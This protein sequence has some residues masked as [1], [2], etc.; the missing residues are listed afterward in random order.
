MWRDT[1]LENQQRIMNLKVVPRYISFPEEVLGLNKIFSVVGPRRSGKTF[2]LASVIKELVRKNKLEYEQL[3][4]IDF[5]ELDILNA[6]F[7]SIKLEFK[8]LYPDLEPYFV[9]DELQEVPNFTSSLIQ[10]YNQGD[11]IFVTGSN[12]NLLSQEL[13]T[14]LRGRNFEQKVLPLS[15]KEY[16]KFNTKDYSG[17]L[18][19]SKKAVLKSHLDTFLKYGGYPELAL[20][21]SPDLKRS[22]LDNYYKTIVF[23]DLMDRYKIRNEYALKYLM[24]RLVMN[25]GKAT[26]VHR[27]YNELKSQNLKI[28]KNTLYEYLEFLENIFWVFPVNNYANPKGQKKYYLYDP[29]F[30][31]I[32]HPDVQKGP[33]LENAVFVEEKRLGKELFY[34]SSG[35]WEIDLYSPETSTATKIC[36]LL[37][38]QN[39]RRETAVLEKQIFNS[40]RLLYA[41]SESLLSNISTEIEQIETIDYFLANR[42]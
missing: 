18:S 27:I 7:I 37:T 33:S 15:F 35:S 19:R 14:Q 13:A 12:A 41:Q 16:L 3:V 24:K 29:G 22:L 5:A 39:V 1:I 23:Q 28:S 34:L 20:V 17:P 40:K 31:E 6:D 10:L 36:Q 11:P 32:L 25:I 2:Y 38:P 9:F 8:Q 21:E 26:S 30:I 42:K 4:W